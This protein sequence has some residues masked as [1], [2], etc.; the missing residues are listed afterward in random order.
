[1]DSKDTK[2]EASIYVEY[3][4]CKFTQNKSGLKKL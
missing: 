3:P 1:V 4:V 2:M